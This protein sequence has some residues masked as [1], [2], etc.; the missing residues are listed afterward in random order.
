MVR[1]SLKTAVSLALLLGLVGC[2]GADEGATLPDETAD[3]DVGEVRTSSHLAGTSPVGPGIGGTRWRWV[4]AH[5]TEGPLELGERG[6]AQFLEANAT[7]Q[8]LVLVYDQKFD[9]DGEAAQS[10]VETV[11]QR[12]TPGPEVDA[13]WRIAEEA[14]ITTGVCPTER[15]QDRPGDVRMRG[16]FLEV[17]TQRSVWCNG[18]EVRHVYAPAP[19]QPH[20]GAQL[21]R[22]YAAHFNRQ[23]AAAVTSLFAQQGSLVQPFDRTPEGNPRR[24]DG[25]QAIYEW[26]QEAFRNTPW[27][28]LRPTRMLPGATDGT[29][30]LEWRYMDPR[31]DVPFAGRNLFLVAGGEIFEGTIEITSQT[32]DP[33]EELPPTLDETRP[34]APAVATTEAS[35]SAGAASADGDDATAATEGAAPV[36]GDASATQTTES[37][38]EA[39]PAGEAPAEAPDAATETSAE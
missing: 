18:L 33:E 11:V 27:L 2:G 29:F 35:A 21:L 4:E 17:Y 10:C 19:T 36:E 20:D 28:A 15:E 7:P 6:F 39:E 14:R 8:G 34:A 5:C 12:A 13:E 24:H 16:D 22:H 26:Y 9:D 38:A 32:T 1:S 3:L 30:I 31:L 25:R 23:D 37:P